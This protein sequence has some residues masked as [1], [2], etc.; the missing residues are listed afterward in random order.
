MVV[1]MQDTRKMWE[2]KKYSQTELLDD[3]SSL[4]YTISVYQESINKTF[5]EY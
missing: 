2:L 3:E 1:I 5:D 4:G